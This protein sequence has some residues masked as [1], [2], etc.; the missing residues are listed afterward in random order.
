M[1]LDKYNSLFTDYE[2]SSIK[3][4][5]KCRSRRVK[6]DLKAPVCT[7]CLKHDALCDITDHI[8]YSFNTMAKLQDKIIE[9][10]KNLAENHII[11]GS[12]SSVDITNNPNRKRRVQYFDDTSTLS[13]KSSLLEKIS[14]EVGTL[15]DGNDTAIYYGSGQG[16]LFLKIFLSELHHKILS[17]FWKK[18]TESD[19]DITGGEEDRHF[20][21][22]SASIP[23]SHIIDLLW[24]NYIKDVYQFYPFLSL[25]Q[26]R[27]IF[28][29]SKQNFSKLHP[30]EKFTFFMILAISSHLSKQM[31]GYRMLLD[32]NSPREYYTNAMMYFAS[33]ELK[34]GI[35][36]VSCLLLLLIWLSINDSSSSS[37]LWTLSRFIVSYCVEKGM[38]RNI[39]AS[40]LNNFDVEFRNRIWWCT[41]IFERSVSCKTGRVVSIRNAAIDASLP[42]FSEEFDSLT[43]RESAIAV[44]YNKVKFQ[45]FYLLAKISAL[46]G[47]IMESIFL[48]IDD[49]K[50]K[51]S[52]SIGETHKSYDGL[53]EELDQWLE[54]IIELYS[55][56]HP[57]LFLKMKLVYCYHS[58]LLTRP[59]PQFP[60]FSAVVSRICLKDSMEY[61]RIMNNLASRGQ[62]FENWFTAHDLIINSLTFLYSIKSLKESPKIVADT[63]KQI[64]KLFD[65][66]GVA[67]PNAIKFVKLYELLSEAVMV[68]LSGNFVYDNPNDNM[69]GVNECVSFDPRLFEFENG[70]NNY[71]Y[72]LK[73]ITNL[74]QGSPF[75]LLDQMS[76]HR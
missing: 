40:T 28:E 27:R 41:Y 69:L 9:Y 24:G 13:E 73:Y 71:D 4:C 44:D 14:Y 50:P 32:V 64:V 76:N 29:K 57:T 49:G 5:S 55:E 68:Y 70:S 38:H 7:N 47:D 33:I 36:F 19:K 16:S 66:I 20:L 31:E 43:E 65:V 35:N 42:R 46:A 61:F 12:M 22:A 25:T 23:N 15:L 37:D 3:S 1:W 72:I 8:Y 67:N 30:G 52:F 48:T 54:T 11:E 18:A 34:D 45:P 10:E 56:K 63:N 59:S 60:K 74:S 75:D 6:C 26:V 58:L 17:N 53:R 39:R 21:T 2:P 62:H 51:G